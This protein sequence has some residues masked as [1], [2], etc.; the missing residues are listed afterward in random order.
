MEL[1]PNVPISQNQISENASIENVKAIDNTEPE[2]TKM[3]AV[4]RRVMVKRGLCRGL[5]VPEIVSEFA[6]YRKITVSEKTIDRDIA[7]IRQRVWQDIKKND[8]PIH[9]LL[10]DFALKSDEIYKQLWLIFINSFDNKEKISALRGMNE[11]IIGK[12]KILQNLGVDTRQLVT[13][14][15]R[16]V[17]VQ[18]QKHS[19]NES[20]SRAQNSIVLENNVQC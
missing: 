8:K 3:K 12:V 15:S 4:F 19:V 20:E 2:K 9:S 18:W 10:A 13:M 6:K 7:I 1:S 17:L 16:E 14:Q 5:T 11:S